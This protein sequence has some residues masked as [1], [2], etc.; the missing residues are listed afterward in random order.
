MPESHDLNPY[1]PPGSS[2]D[3][4]VND[5]PV[6]QEALQHVLSAVNYAIIEKQQNDDDET[7]IDA[8]EICRMVL[9]HACRMT[10]Y[11]RSGDEAFAFLTEIK[12]HTSEDVG[13][14]VEQLDR[15]G[16]TRAD[17]DDHP[18]DF[19]SLFDLAEPAAE[20]SLPFDL[21]AEMAFAS[22]NRDMNDDQST[23]R[24]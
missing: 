5:S 3:A 16:L 22:N 19:D 20:W 2:N 1:A 17:E 10:A 8:K 14:A 15:L 6:T 13:R 21:K 11:D 23:P 24:H 12:L 4:P 18:S 7:H 9:S